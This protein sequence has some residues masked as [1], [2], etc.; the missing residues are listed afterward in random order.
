MACAAFA[1]ANTAHAQVATILKP[2]QIG[3]AA[4]AAVPVSDLGNSF[5]TGFNVTGTIAINVPLLP[6]GFRIDAAYNQF[7]AKGTSNV[8]AKIAGVSGN[9]VFSIPGAVI[10]SPYLIGGVG[11]YRVS[12]SATGSVA[13]NN[14]AA[15][16]KQYQKHLGKDLELITITFDPVHDQ[17]GVL[18][19]YAKTWK[20]DPA[21][22]HFLTGPV[23]D[24]ER[25]C[26]LFGVNYV[27]DEG[28][29]VHSLHTAVIDREGKLAVNL[30]GNEFT[31]Q[32]FA[33][34]VGSVL[35]SR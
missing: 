2:V 4:G 12:S 19:D 33:D 16:Q 28:L 20:A 14:F 6:I 18:R 5:S 23:G 27:P 17:P 8:N 22:W 9:V 7:G 24:V 11:Y 35:N 1:P 31:A 13:S 34:L 3:V 10:I 25:V 32:Q 15:I 29:F 30:E 21:T 26:D